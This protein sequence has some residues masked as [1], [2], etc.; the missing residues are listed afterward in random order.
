MGQSPSLRGENPA[1][2][3]ETSVPSNPQLGLAYCTKMHPPTKHLP[4]AHWES[5][6][7]GVRGDVSEA[8]GAEADVLPSDSVLCLW[9]GWP[10]AWTQKVRNRERRPAETQFGP[11]AQPRVQ[12][13]QGTWARV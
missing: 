1:Q 5:V 7:E 6:R 3:S 4:K 13:T 10:S 9:V 11:G 12:S 8:H 2:S